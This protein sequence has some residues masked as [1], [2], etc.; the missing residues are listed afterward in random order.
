MPDKSAPP[1]L[2]NPSAAKNDP[3]P[4]SQSAKPAAALPGREGAK[5]GA[6]DHI[7]NSDAETPKRSDDLGKNVVGWGTGQTAEDVEKT[8]SRTKEIN[9]A[10]VDKMK[11]K[12]LQ[13][14]W[15]EK[16]LNGYNKAYEDGKAGTKNTL[17]NKQL[18]PRKELMEKILE[19][20]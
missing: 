19:N 17:G 8:K 15:V 10:V 9:P 18:L 6:T 4:T 5:V 20:W 16:Q 2:T 12:G 13:K 3:L 7:L 11:E 1:V 14:D